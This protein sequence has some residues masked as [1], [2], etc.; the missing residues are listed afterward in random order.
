MGIDDTR[1][2]QREHEGTPV[3][4]G[5]KEGICIR[6]GIIINSSNE[7]EREVGMDNVHG[8]KRIQAMDNVCVMV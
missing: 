4:L 6:E 5:A 2:N 3:T 8:L 7:H 1:H